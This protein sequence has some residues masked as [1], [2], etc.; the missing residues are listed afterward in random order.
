LS[1]IDEELLPGERDEEARKQLQ[2][3]LVT[4]SDKS[5][6][7]NSNTVLAAGLGNLLQKT[8]S[9]TGFLDRDF[10]R[11]TSDRKAERGFRRRQ[12]SRQDLRQVI[13]QDRAL[14]SVK[15]YCLR[16]YLDSCLKNLF[17]FPV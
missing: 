5:S 14:C 15:K 12:D 1:L 11:R 4:V 8:G 17:C 9:E 3:V 10:Q 7:K 13:K 6:S 16:S 2:C